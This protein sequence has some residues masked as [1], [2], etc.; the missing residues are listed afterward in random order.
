MNSM[1]ISLDTNIWIFGIRELNPYCIGIL[2]R[3]PTFTT[4]IPNQVRLELERNLSEVHMRRFYE[5]LRSSGAVID[6]EPVPELMIAEFEERGLRKGDAVIAAF[7]QHHAI[8]LFISDNRDFLR[9][10]APTS[11]FQII[12]P[13]AFC[14]MFEITFP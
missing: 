10:L 5:L 4:I 8:A 1:V 12:A 6:Y 13:Q 11:P 7:C 2:G 14:E 9:T 3:L